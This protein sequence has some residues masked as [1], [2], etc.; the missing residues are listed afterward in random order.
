MGEIL[1]ERPLLCEKRLSPSPPLPKSGWRLAGGLASGL[2]P[3]ER[4]GTF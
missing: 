3:P 1:G 2:V 4:V